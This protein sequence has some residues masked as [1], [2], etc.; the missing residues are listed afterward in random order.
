[1]G[2]KNLLNVTFVLDPGT[3]Q[4]SKDAAEKSFLEFA[5]K[6]GIEEVQACWVKD[7]SV[8]DAI[9][10]K[11]LLRSPFFWGGLAWVAVSVLRMGFSG[12]LLSTAVAVAAFSIAALFT[13]SQGL[14]VRKWVKE[15]SRKN[16]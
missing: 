3:P 12:T 13:T 11:N 16:A 4:T 7:R 6:L 15:L 8:E 2:E 10:T 14:E 1:M 5:V 9:S